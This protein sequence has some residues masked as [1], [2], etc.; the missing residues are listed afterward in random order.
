MIHFTIRSLTI[1]LVPR[2]T[3][4]YVNECGLASLDL[5]CLCFEFETQEPEPQILEDR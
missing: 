1:S 4:G 5:G 3:F 2:F